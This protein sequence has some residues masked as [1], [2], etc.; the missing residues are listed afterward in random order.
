M[1]FFTLLGFIGLF[2]LFT[3]WVI[4][5]VAHLL[6]IERFEF[7]TL[8]AWVNLGINMI[9]GTVFYEYFVAKSI[10]LLGALPTNVTTCLVIPIT[11]GI[12][13]IWNGTKLNAFYLIG[14]LTIV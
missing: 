3:S 6:Y 12:D 1:S 9:L 13:V 5:V 8:N 4:V 2:T 14:T 11:F 7:P 10:Y